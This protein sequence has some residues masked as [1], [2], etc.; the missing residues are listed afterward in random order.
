[1]RLSA[2]TLIL[3]SSLNGC[4]SA[5]F[6]FFLLNVA[7]LQWE[8]TVTSMASRCTLQSG[9]QLPKWAV[10]VSTGQDGSSSVVSIGQ[11]VQCVNLHEK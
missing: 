6:F 1:M 5:Q 7:N 8:V 9:S 4:Y 11:Q 10:V 2:L 3:V